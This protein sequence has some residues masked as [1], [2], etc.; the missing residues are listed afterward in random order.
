MGCLADPEVVEDPDAFPVG[1]PEVAT[2]LPGRDEARRVA[3]DRGAVVDLDAPCP[4]G[5][6]AVPLQ[7]DADV[8][9]TD[10][11]SN[12]RWIVSPSC[13]RRTSGRTRGTG[14][15]GSTRV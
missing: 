2:S 13:A 6:D 15:I 5:G 1:V 12:S 9:A 3:A 8:P 7:M 11:V 4:T 14:F 10:P